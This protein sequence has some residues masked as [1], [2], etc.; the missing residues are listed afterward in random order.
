MASQQQENIEKFFAARVAEGGVVVRNAPR[1]DLDLYI[2]NYRG[3]T[4]F[5]RLLLIGR[6]SVPLC[7][8]ALKA[9][10]REAKKGKDLQRYNDVC[11][12]LQAVCPDDAESQFD[13]NWAA[14]T[15]RTNIATTRQLEGELKGYKNNLVKESI[16][17]AHRELGAHLES[18]GD[19]PGATEAYV[20]MRPDSSSQAHITEVG[21][22]LIKCLIQR[23]DWAGVLVNANKL[24]SG[25]ASGNESNPEKPYQRMVS[26]LAYMGLERYADAAKCFIDAGDPTHCQAYNDIASVNDVAAYGGLLALATMDRAQLQSRVLDSPSFRNYLELES[27]IRKAIS[28]FISGRY[29]A[30]L[31]IVDAYSADYLLDLYLQPHTTNIIS[32]IRSKC[33]I[34]YFVPFSCVTLES[35]NEAFGAPDWDLAAELV[36]MI[37]QGQL[38]ARINTIDKLLVAVSTDPRVAM[39][40]QALQAAKE[41][42]TQVLDRVRRMSLVAAKLRV[43]ARKRRGDDTAGR[44]LPG[45]N[46]I[47][48][49]DK[50]GPADFGEQT[51]A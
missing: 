18:I 5:E 4:R 21:R 51:A 14:A 19:L 11:E 50:H 25:S 41:Y 37:R 48:P 42:Q 24:M 26:G 8:D 36:S 44:N 3:R 6:C 33:I 46:E 49:Q 16:R 20:K 34:Q 38:R 1:F 7:I 9:A 23:R 40:Q 15:E 35:M 29:A 22:H 30:C 13:T 10:A 32:M 47:F 31:A 2:S 28:M 27:H 45:A 39:Q 17:I 43:K 12:L